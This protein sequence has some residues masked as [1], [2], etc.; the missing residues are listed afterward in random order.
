MPYRAAS[1]TRPSVSVLIANFNYGRFIRSAAESVIAQ[2]YEDLQIIIVDDGS[3]DDS[4]EIICSLRNEFRHRVRGFDVLLLSEN[5]GKLQALNVVIPLVTGEL[6]LILDSDDLL[7]D[8]F[9][10]VL[11]R[12]LFLCREKDPRTAFVYS[13][14]VLVDEENREI[15]RGRSAPF[16]PVALKT[17]SYIPD[18]APTMTSALRQI[19]PLDPAIRSG[20]KHHKWLRLVGDGWVGSYVPQPLFRY[21]M[22]SGNISRIGERVL[23]DIGRSESKERILSG[24][25]P[26]QSSSG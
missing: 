8:G 7:A 22:H 5:G 4:P 23:T 2:H 6:T 21:R 13:D 3:S 19:L 14:C 25:W 26:Q 11:T 20:T 1:G 15:G 9:L 12:E 18:C 17:A 24:Y 16:D 10:D